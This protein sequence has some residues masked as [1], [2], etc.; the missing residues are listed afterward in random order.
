MSC[1]TRLTLL[2]ILGAVF[3][4]QAASAAAVR[5]PT[6]GDPAFAFDLPPGWT[7]SSDAQSALRIADDDHSAFVYLV[8]MVD[9][10]S[11]SNIAA[12]FLAAAGAE[13]Y[14][15]T[16]PGTIAGLP[17][18][19]FISRFPGPGGITVALRL[20]LVKL[21]PSHCAAQTSVTLPNATPAQIAALTALLAQVRLTGLK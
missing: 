20:V 2:F 12:D 3:A 16:E 14:T 19:A 17:G 7:A 13:P 5:E 11:T 21:D 9:P 10:T 6:T 4:A 18:D 15:A 8:V 1:R